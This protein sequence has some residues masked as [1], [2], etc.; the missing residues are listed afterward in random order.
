M[1]SIAE[2][3]VLAVATGVA[4]YATYAQPHGWPIAVSKDY[5]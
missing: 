5:V 2:A 4:L 3:W 1:L